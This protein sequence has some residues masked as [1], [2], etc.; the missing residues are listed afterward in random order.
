MRFGRRRRR[1]YNIVNPQSPRPHL[2][3]PEQLDDPFAPRNLRQHDDRRPMPIRLLG[4]GA[5]ALIAFA[6]LGLNLYNLQVQKT[7]EFG[8]LADQNRVRRE[9]TLA[10][11][12]IIFD[13]HGN[14]LV[15]NV[16]SD[17]V[18]VVPVDLPVKATERADTLSRLQLAIGVAPAEVERLVK[19]HA[20]EPFQPIVLK[21]QLDANTRLV[22]NENLPLMRGVRLVQSTARH[23]LNG[24]GLAHIL[25]YVGKLDQ[26]EYDALHAKGYQFDD[27]IGKT[28]LEFVD[29]KYL[30]GK[31]GISVVERD[32]RGK[33]V[34]P[35]VDTPPVPGNNVY[36]TLDMSLQQEAATDLQA[37]LD[38]RHKKFGGNRGIAGSAIVMNPQTGELLSY[39]SLPDFDI[40]QFAAGITVPQYQALLSDPRKPLL[41]RS[42]GGQYPPGS[43]FKPVTSA[44]A[45]QSG[46][47]NRNTNIFCPGFLTRGG[48]TF[49]CWNLGGHGNQDVITAIAHSCDVFF[50]TVADQ[51]GDIL[52]NKVARDFG[53]G[54]R[55][56][57]DLT[58]EARGIAPDRNWKKTYFADAFQATGDPGWKDAFWY[59]GNTITYGIGQS[60]L[61]TTPLQDLNWT[62]TVANGGNYMR[63]QLTG[64]VTGVDGTMVHPFKPVIDHRVATDPTELA[65]IREG[66]RY[67]VNGPGGTAYLLKGL[68]TASGKTGTAQYGT[69][70]DKGNLPEHAWFTGYAPLVDPEVA[71]LVFIEGGGEGNEAAEPVAA[72]ILNFYFAHRDSI[73]AGITNQ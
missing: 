29:E 38:E 58:G 46:T 21:E 11:R 26:E 8:H 67:A 72:K 51:M 28:G 16:G 18:A 35:I 32:S 25:G 70:D 42:I 62:A 23:Y 73:R 19:L 4:F 20:R 37:M 60:F 47:I 44:A 33:E 41:D 22:L 24:A 53:V 15:T 63:P 64:P 3:S 54:R 65:I 39:V 40:N 9:I 14:Q 31:P 43:T 2:G 6:A 59:E 36:L 45:L 48:S 66:L 7:V 57:I 13:R 10:P 1:D 56:G 34:R 12:G 30:R 17:A 52:L 61:L 71:V 69:P 68:P 5:F 55:T 50:Y 49:R 27:N